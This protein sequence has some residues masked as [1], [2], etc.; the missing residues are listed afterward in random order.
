MGYMAE[1][2]TKDSLREPRKA[3]VYE[4]LNE[5]SKYACNSV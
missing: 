4:S 2:F 5:Y 3:P 1:S